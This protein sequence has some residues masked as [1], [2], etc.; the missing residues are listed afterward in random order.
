MF[1]FF[2][3]LLEDSLQEDHVVRNNDDFVKL[4]YFFPQFPNN[5]SVS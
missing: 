2:D 3:H 1:I 5:R 4:K